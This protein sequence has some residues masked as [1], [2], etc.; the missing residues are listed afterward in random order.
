M[1]IR[2]CIYRDIGGFRFVCEILHNRVA[3]PY[4]ICMEMIYLRLQA[5]YSNQPTAVIVLK[6]SLILQKKSFLRTRLSTE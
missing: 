4:S 1:L 5:F 3:I 2:Q 6:I